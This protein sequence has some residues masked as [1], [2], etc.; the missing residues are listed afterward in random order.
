MA[1]LLK[2]NVDNEGSAG[3]FNGVGASE[4]SLPFRASLS[5]AP[6]LVAFLSIVPIAIPIVIKI[7]MKF[8]GSMESRM[9][10]KD[11]AWE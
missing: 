11:A 3:F 8:Y 6:P 5:H 9:M 1:L 10:V 7:W 4:P 2:V